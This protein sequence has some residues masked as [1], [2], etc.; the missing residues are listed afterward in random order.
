M[1]NKETDDITVSTSSTLP[2]MSE[3]SS[4]SWSDDETSSPLIE[5]YNVPLHYTAVSWGPSLAAG[6]SPPKEPQKK[7]LSASDYE[8]KNALDAL[9]GSISAVIN[10]L[11][12]AGVPKPSADELEKNLQ[13]GRYFPVLNRVQDYIQCIP[14]DCEDERTAKIH[15]AVAAWEALCRLKA[16]EYRRAYKNALNLRYKLEMG[17]SRRGRRL[18]QELSEAISIQVNLAEQCTACQKKLYLVQK[19]QKKHLRQMKKSS[20]IEPQGYQPIRCLH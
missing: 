6:P 18:Q 8:I 5:N 1:H 17:E 12:S 19:W 14:S 15:L 11:R 13:M 7:R 4:R 2:W 3:N 9:V 10:F 20:A 16:L